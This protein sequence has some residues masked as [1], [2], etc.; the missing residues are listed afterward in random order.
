MWSYLGLIEAQW[1]L[2]LLAYIGTLLLPAIAVAV[3]LPDLGDKLRQ[4]KE[5]ADARADMFDDE[6]HPR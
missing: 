5:L 2:I 1:W 3:Y 6:R 4:L